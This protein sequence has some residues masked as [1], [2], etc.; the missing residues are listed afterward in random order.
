MRPGPNGG[1][2]QI[3]GSPGNPGGGRPPSAIRGVCRQSFA[4]RI[5]IMEQIA[6]SDSHDAADRLK[7]IDI[8]GKYG[9]DARTQMGTDEVREK[10]RATVQII[11]SE[12][13]TDLA[14]ML[15]SRIRPVWTT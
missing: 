6:D 5:P 2:L 3:G 13:G 9:L 12:L 7:A 8:L 1:M 10:L 11:R 15:V 14:E 4:A